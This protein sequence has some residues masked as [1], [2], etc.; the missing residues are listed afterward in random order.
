M[1]FALS[2]SAE[3][4][5]DIMRVISQDEESM[6]SFRKAASDGLAKA[7]G[8]WMS[9]RSVEGE[10]VMLEV[11]PDGTGFRTVVPGGKSSIE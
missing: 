3:L 4:P 6:R 10:M 2:F 11:T 8:D 7:I 9:K 1:K 5:V